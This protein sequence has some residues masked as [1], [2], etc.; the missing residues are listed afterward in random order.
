MGRIFLL[1]W[2]RSQYKFA[3]SYTAANTNSVFRTLL[4]ARFEFLKCKTAT[5][6][7]YCNHWQK[8]HST[9]TGRR[10]EVTGVMERKAGPHIHPCDAH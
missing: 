9:G 2:D 8:N 1:L 10:N 6:D 3:I 4:G 5:P 7:W